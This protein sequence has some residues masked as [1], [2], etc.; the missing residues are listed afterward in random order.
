MQD[1]VSN[2]DFIIFILIALMVLIMSISVLGAKDMSHAI[3]YLA[4]AFVGIAGMY[5]LLANEF[6][7]AIQMTVYAGGVIVLFLFALML[8][9]TEEFV[10]RGNTGGVRTRFLII[11][12]FFAII[13]SFTVMTT[14][15]ELLWKKI[16][17]FQ[18]SGAGDAIGALGIALFDIYS[19]SFFILAFILIVVLIG[20]IYLIKNEG[21]PEPI[22]DKTD[23]FPGG[24]AENSSPEKED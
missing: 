2:I 9:R 3:I 22:L 12:L 17:V 14:F 20:A 21:E 7:F 5:L 6:L 1:L 4:M 8:T 19:A 15:N 16:P 24:V 18:N 13:F 23:F 10:V 11:F